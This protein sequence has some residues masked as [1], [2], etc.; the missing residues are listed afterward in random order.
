MNT[1]KVKTTVIIFLSL[2]VIGLIILVAILSNSTAELNGKLTTQS[3]QIPNPAVK[4]R[5]RNP[6]QSPLLCRQN[7][8]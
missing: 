2:L 1:E 6:C 7:R 8:T 4:R 5:S 3:A